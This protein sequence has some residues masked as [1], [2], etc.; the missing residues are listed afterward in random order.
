MYQQIIQ[1]F[2]R[3]AH[4]PIARYGHDHF[5]LAT[6]MVRELRELSYLDQWKTCRSNEW[7]HIEMEDLSLLLFTEGATSSYSYLQCPLDVPSYRQF[8]EQ[9]GLAFSTQNRREN[10]DDYSMLLETAGLRQ[11]LTPMRYDLDPNGYRSGVHPLAHIHIGLS[12]NVRIGIRKKMT[13][14]A[15]VLFV[16]RQAYPESWAR[17]LQQK[18]VGNVPKKIRLECND[19]E[20][21]W[22]QQH[23]HLELHLA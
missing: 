4:F 3:A 14:L 16:M 2:A 13:P 18:E 19:V 6:E 12:N 8:L 9:R 7:F 15:F 21:D 22:W 11:H 10:L 1:Q 20:N 5:A 23:D 17:L